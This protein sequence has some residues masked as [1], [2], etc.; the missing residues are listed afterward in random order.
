MPAVERRRWFGPLGQ[1]RPIVIASL[2]RK[3]PID[4]R[5]IEQVNVGRQSALL[6]A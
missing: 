6:I 4:F 2:I 3:Q 1:C 5:Q